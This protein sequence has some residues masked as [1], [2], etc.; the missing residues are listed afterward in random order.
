MVQHDI[1]HGVLGRVGDHVPVRERLR[2]S[3]SLIRAVEPGD[4]PAHGGPELPGCLAAAARQ[5]PILHLGRDVVGQ[6]EHG[7]GQDPGVHR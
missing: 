6:A 5:H 4:R 1:G 2:M 7:A 3:G